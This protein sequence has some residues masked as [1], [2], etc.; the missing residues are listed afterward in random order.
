MK[1]Y[2]KE[3]VKLGRSHTLRQLVAH[4]E[5]LLHVRKSL[6]D[7]IIRTSTDYKPM[8]KN[9]RYAIVR[10]LKKDY[11]LSDILAI[12]N[13]IARIKNPKLVRTIIYHAKDFKKTNAVKTFSMA[14]APELQK[15]FKRCFLMYIKYNKNLNSLSILSA[16][17]RKIDMYLSSNKHLKL[18][19]NFYLETFAKRAIAEIDYEVKDVYYIYR[20]VSI[21]LAIRLLRA[22]NNYDAI[23][24]NTRFVDESFDGFENSPLGSIKITDVCKA[25]TGVVD[26]AFCNIIRAAVPQ[27]RAVMTEYAYNQHVHQFGGYWAENSMIGQWKVHDDDYHFVYVT[28]SEYEGQY[29]PFENDDDDTYCTNRLLLDTGMTQY[30][31]I[32]K[33][34]A[35]S[36]TYMLEK[37]KHPNKRDSFIRDNEVIIPERRQHSG[38]QRSYVTEEEYD[39]NLRAAIAYKSWYSTLNRKD[40]ISLDLNTFEA[41]IPLNGKVYERCPVCGSRYNASL[42]KCPVCKV[43]NA[44]AKVSRWAFDANYSKDD[45]YFD[46]IDADAYANLYEQGIDLDSYTSEEFNDYVSYEWKD[47]IAAGI[48]PTTGFV[49]SYDPFEDAFNSEYDEDDYEEEEDTEQ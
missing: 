23:V 33:D 19:K 26:T 4:I 35:E 46:D 32:K 16:L 41:D 7:T 3:L 8:P 44:N 37:M 2:L 12:D 9:Y 22:A 21:E 39:L 18:D 1:K 11:T 31:L 20:L 47:E 34:S 24:R 38:H 17:D 14:K 40:Q 42:V 15:M 29:V 30:D 49:A 6:R 13:Y 27:Y 10:T 28:I 5:A 43:H 45:P 36:I 25:Y 48:D